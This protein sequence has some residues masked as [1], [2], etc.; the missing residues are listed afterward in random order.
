L[1]HHA[2]NSKDY[3]TTDNCH[4]YLFDALK[5]SPSEELYKAAKALVLANFP[6]YAKELKEYID[7][8]QESEAASKEGVKKEGDEIEKK[9]GEKQKVADEAKKEEKEIPFLAKLPVDILTELLSED[10]LQVQQEIEVVKVVEGYIKSRKSI[11]PLLEEEDPANDEAIV[12]ILTEDEKK[13]REDAKAKK[14]EESK[15]L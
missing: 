8:I 5:F 7:A 9:E 6:K 14:A 15:K 1:Q 4:L 11:S 13:A 10:T 12:S 3:L 2:L